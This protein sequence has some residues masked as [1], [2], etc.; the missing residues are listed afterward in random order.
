MSVK[1]HSRFVD[2]TKA[3]DTVSRDALW[4]IMKKSG[5]P[6]RFV[7]VVQQFHDGSERSSQYML[8]SLMMALHQ[9]QG[10]GLGLDVSVSRRSGD[11]PT[12]GLGLISK[13]IVN[14]SVA[15][16]RRLGLV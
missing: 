12:S 3:F 15:G 14:V 16:G 1:F 6:N 7:K 8:W 11:V 4:K 9:K 5:C 13:K 10:C 2:L